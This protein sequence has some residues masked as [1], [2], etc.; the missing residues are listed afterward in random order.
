MKKRKIKKKVERSPDLNFMSAEEYVR[1]IMD[2]ETAKIVR[3]TPTVYKNDRIVREYEFE[4][5]AVVH[6]EWQEQALGAF[7]HQFTLVQAPKPNPGKLRV[8]IIK[9]INY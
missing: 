4:D 3:E 6:Y 5:G 7:N 9:T 2:D 1:I 8:G